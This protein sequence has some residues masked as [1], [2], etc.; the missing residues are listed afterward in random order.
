MKKKGKE[1]ER[2]IKTIMLAVLLAAAMLASGGKAA[3]QSAGRW[4]LYPSYAD[5][6]EIEPAGG[7]VFVLGSGS[8]YSYN[9]DE[10][11]ITTYDK[12]NTLSDAE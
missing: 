7:N 8:L 2:N 6:T 5:I 12:T 10:G 4:T 3:A 1:V 9:A 11:S